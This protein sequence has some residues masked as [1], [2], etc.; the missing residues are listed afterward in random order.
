MVVVVDVVVVVLVVVIVVVVV[1]VVA[2]ELGKEEKSRGKVPVANPSASGGSGAL[3]CFG[4]AFRNLYL[5]IT[6]MLMIRDKAVIMWL[7]LMYSSFHCL[8]P[9]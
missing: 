2:V 9:T 5:R 7:Q 8:V 3:G 6:T 1:V 4:E